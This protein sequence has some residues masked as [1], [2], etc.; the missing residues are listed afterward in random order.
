[1]NM[2]QSSPTAAA[3]RKI[4]SAAFYVFLAT[5]I[6]AP[7]SFLPTSYVPLELVKTAVISLG[8]LISLFLYALAAFRE[9]SVILPPKS[10]LWTGLLIGVSLILSSAFSIQASKSFFGQG[11][12]LGAGSFLITLLLA[13]LV[14]FAIVAKRTDRAIVLYAG[15]FGAFILVWLI[16]I[17]RLL[18]G[19]GFMSLGF[20]SSVTSSMVGNC[21]HSAY[22]Q[23]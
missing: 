1:M 20:L 13:G 15:L 2:D 19:S 21:S 4:E 16:Q 7:L 17:L 8:T 18:A 10:I 9:R 22:S 5:V 11:F 3:S 6:L 23:P 12:E 14:A